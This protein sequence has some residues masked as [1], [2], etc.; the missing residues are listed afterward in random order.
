MDPDSSRDLVDSILEPGM[1]FYEGKSLTMLALV[2]MVAA[3]AVLV[4]L[5]KQPPPARL[6]PSQFVAAGM[7][8][9]T[10][11]Y[12]S[13]H[14]EEMKA[15]EDDCTYRGISPLADTPEARDCTAAMEAAMQ[16]FATSGK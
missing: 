15:R 5:A 14:R 11:A 1:R 3:C 4:I 6:A 10:V 7:K 12:Y 8:P 2:A 13:S 16:I 9:K